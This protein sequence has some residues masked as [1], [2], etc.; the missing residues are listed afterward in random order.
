MAIVTHDEVKLP[1]ISLPAIFA[2]VIAD[3]IA[4]TVEYIQGQTSVDDS[5]GLTHELNWPR[6]YRKSFA[7]S[8]SASSVRRLLCTIVE[9]P[10]VFHSISA[11]MLVSSDSAGRW[12]R[13]TYD[14]P[15]NSLAFAVLTW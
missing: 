1:F 11:T 10:H 6:L 5:E 4:R 7:R 3:E 2:V 8:P 15:P 14:P 9:V 13:E 12:I